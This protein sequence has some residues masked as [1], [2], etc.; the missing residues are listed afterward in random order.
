MAAPAPWPGDRESGTPPLPPDSH[1]ESEIKSVIRYSLKQTR[2][3]GFIYYSMRVALIVL[4]V[5]A[6]A[7]GIE[8]LISRAPALSL[9]VAIG[10]GIDTWLKPGVRHKIHY[11]Y[12]DLFRKLLTELRF[13]DA[14]DA[15][16]LKG[17]KKQFHETD[18]A[19]RKEVFSV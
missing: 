13:A 8:F 9:L 7:K 3:F 17:I 19:Y 12:H 5:C 15:N 16:A 11:T 6:S 10:T 4:S 1:L 18:D 2:I 14:H